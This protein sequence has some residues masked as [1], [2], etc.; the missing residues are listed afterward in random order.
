MRIPMLKIRRFHDLLI[1]N[2]AI[3]IPVK[4]GLYIEMGPWILGLVCNYASVYIVI[5]GLNNALW[6]QAIIYT[7][8]YQWFSAKLQYRNC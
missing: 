5:I 1:F 7:S 2:M 3:P 4:D 8:L 6:H